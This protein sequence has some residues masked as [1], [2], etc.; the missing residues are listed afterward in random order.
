MG[1]GSATLRGGMVGAGAWSAVQLAAWA[2]VQG[3]HIVALTDR[4]DERLLP[5]ADRFG[6]AGRFH[7]A[8]EML[9]AEQL[10]F[11]DICTQPYSH[12]LLIRL[13]VDQGVAVICQKPFGRSM[14]EA[15]SLVRLC[16][17]A[18]VRLMINENFR[19]QA[20]YRRARALLEAG[21]LGAPFFARIHKRRRITLPTF[22]DPQVY[23]KT[24]PRLLAFEM[25]VHYLD[26]MRFL[27]GEPRTLYARLQKVS[28]EIA[29]EDMMHIVLGYDGLT[30][31]ITNSWA[32]VPA[33]NL[34]Q[35]LTPTAHVSPPRLE[36][37]GTLGTL[38]LDA[39]GVLHLYTD[40]E[41][42]QWQMPAEARPESRVAVQQHFID[43]L[44]RGEPFESDPHDT[45]KTMALVY[46]VYDADETGQVITFP[47]P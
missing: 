43:C 30:A 33:V 8:A 19:W 10:D 35:P 39:H 40:S 31:V 36:I 29:G 45:L 14:E 2:Q 24:M 9:A 23:F 42:E 13:A 32:S 4:H 7:D 47:E 38:V 22:A 37:D 15:E 27:F 17:A 26:T 20:W 1:M 6:I 46:A 21:R 41:H 18:G 11:L 44:R 25:G 34:D 5:L 28:R 16:D 3:A 12:D